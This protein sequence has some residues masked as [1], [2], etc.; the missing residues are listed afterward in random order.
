MF[1]EMVFY[2]KYYL[3]EYG[4]EAGIGMG[5]KGVGCGGWEGERGK[6][7]MRGGRAGLLDIHYTV[8][9]HELE[10]LSVCQCLLL[11][12]SNRNQCFVL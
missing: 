4:N 2:C 8:L 9:H 1:S 11:V 10:G 7:R 6:E 5:G 3:V 12:E